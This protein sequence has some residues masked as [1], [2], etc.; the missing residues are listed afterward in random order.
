MRCE[1]RMQ[2]RQMLR[3]LASKR[4]IFPT[5]REASGAPFAMALEPYRLM[6]NFFQMLIFLVRNVVGQDIENRQIKFV[7]KQAGRGAFFAR[8]YE[9]GCKRGGN[10]LPEPQF[11]YGRNLKPFEIWGWDILRLAKRLPR[12]LVVK[13]SG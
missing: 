9:Y 8:A 7:T 13:R 11:P 6:F 5:T 1:G 2:E 12:Y 4:A 10:L 3:S